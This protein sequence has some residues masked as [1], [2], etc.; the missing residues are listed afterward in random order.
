MWSS[1][2][3]TSDMIALT[4]IFCEIGYFTVQMKCSISHIGEKGI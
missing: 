1:T 2:S 3:M 4:A